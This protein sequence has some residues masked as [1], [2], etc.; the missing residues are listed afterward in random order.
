[1]LSLVL[2]FTT[3]FATLPLSLS[4]RK[5]SPLV[6]ARLLALSSALDTETNKQTKI[7]QRY[8]IY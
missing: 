3:A 1:M 7:S 5:L 4:S 2:A 6:V 8:L